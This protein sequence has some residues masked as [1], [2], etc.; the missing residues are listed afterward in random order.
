MGLWGGLGREL[1]LEDGDAALDSLELAGVA[2]SSVYGLIPDARGPHG[3]AVEV[4][5]ADADEM[6]WP[7]CDGLT[8]EGLANKDDTGRR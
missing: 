5:A 4:N 1:F 3:R 6:R 7:E 2:L 8:H